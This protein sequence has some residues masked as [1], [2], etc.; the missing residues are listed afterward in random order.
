M[1]FQFRYIFVL[2]RLYEL[3]RYRSQTYVF[4]V[5][6]LVYDSSRHITSEKG[7]NNAEC[8]FVMVRVSEVYIEYGIFNIDVTVVYFIYCDVKEIEIAFFTPR[9]LFLGGY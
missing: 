9:Y 3:F 2:K 6:L 1:I 4:T 5:K 7:L 8:P